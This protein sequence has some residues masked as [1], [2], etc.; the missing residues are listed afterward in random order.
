M[1]RFALVPRQSPRTTDS[2]ARL[3]NSAA[4]QRNRGQAY[5]PDTELAPHLRGNDRLRARARER[6]LDAV[7]RERREAHAAHEDLNLRRKV[8]L[9]EL[10]KGRERTGE[11]VPSSRRGLR[12]PHDAPQAVNDDAGRIVYTSATKNNQTQPKP[13]H[14][15]ETRHTP[16]RRSA[17]SCPPRRPR[18]PR[19]RSR[20]FRRGR[21]AEVCVS[22][23]VQG[24]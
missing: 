15:T 19:L 7:E 22:I 14:K 5:V 1:A 11:T 18:H 23:I 10:S 16:Y 20:A 6:A 3:S 9:V 2:L 12:L 21:C 4:K 17:Q 8:P 13:R 24:I